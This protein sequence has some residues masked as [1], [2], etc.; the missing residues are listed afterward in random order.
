[1]KHIRT[2]AALAIV[3]ALAAPAVAA[4]GSGDERTDPD[5]IRVEAEVVAR[6]SVDNPPAGESAGDLE[7]FTQQLSRGGRQVGRISGTCVVISPPAAFQCRAIAELPRGSLVLAA[8]L[9]EGP[10]TGAIT[11]GTGRYRR[12]RGSFLVEPVAEGRERITFRVLR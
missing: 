2:L 5:V 7:V 9:G 8:N 11:G 4:S 3:A 12:A 6:Q 1:M 10:A